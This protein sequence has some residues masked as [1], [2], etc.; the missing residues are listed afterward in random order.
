[1]SDTKSRE[2]SITLL[3]VF[4]FL[5]WWGLVQK[6]VHITSNYKR[7]PGL[8]FMY[9]HWHIKNHK[10]VLEDTKWQLQTTTKKESGSK[11]T[12][13]CHK[14]LHKTRGK[15][16]E[17]ATLIMRDNISSLDKPWIR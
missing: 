17:E 8:F 7:N 16:E 9:Y 3:Y 5:W 2:A 1:M 15:E 6:A 12:Q 11:M 14:S 10:P 13:K 4:F